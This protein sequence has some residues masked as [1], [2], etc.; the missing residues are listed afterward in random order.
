MKKR[1]TSRD[2]QAEETRQRIVNAAVKLFKE[3]HYD[4]ISML[5]IAREANVST[6]ALYH[7]FASK[8]DLAIRFCEVSDDSLLADRASLYESDEHAAILL[9]DFFIGF[10]AASIYAVGVD[11]ASVYFNPCNREVE[12]DTRYYETLDRIIFRGQEKGELKTDMNP[13][14]LSDFLSVAARGAAIDWCRHDGSYDLECRIR[15]Y[16]EILIPSFIADDFKF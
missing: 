7:H 8:Y 4:D 13:H 5:D 2:L 10:Y 9:M 16:M 12:L 6:G 3:N 1:V 15:A 14:A 11:V